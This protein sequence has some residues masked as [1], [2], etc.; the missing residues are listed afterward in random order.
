MLVRFAR[1]R[2]V[3]TDRVADVV[4]AA[5]CDVLVRL[6][7]FQTDSNNPSL[8]GWM[9]TILRRRIADALRQEA[10]QPRPL[11]DSATLTE[12]PVRTDAELDAQA[13]RDWDREVLHIV[14]AMLER[15]ETPENYRILTLRGLEG[16][17]VEEIAT[18]LGMTNEQVRGRL[19]RMMNKLR[20]GVAHYL[21]GDFSDR[22]KAFAG[23][24]H[25]ESEPALE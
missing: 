15:S 12:I 3:P 11:A 5:W 2:G 8:R 14:M 9:C 7:D 1:S 20:T 21:G 24:R 19:A 6:P 4:Q 10:R 18:Q 13:E 25:D 17:T 22:Q 16:H 23:I